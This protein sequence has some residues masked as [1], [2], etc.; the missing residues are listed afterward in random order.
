MFYCGMTRLRNTNLDTFIQFQNT[1]TISREKNM[2]QNLFKK[3]SK[4]V[5]FNKDFYCDITKRGTNNWKFLENTFTGK[6]L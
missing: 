6:L 5:I 2:E 1:R 3:H 4:F